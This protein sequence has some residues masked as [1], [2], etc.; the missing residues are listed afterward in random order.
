M[1]YTNPY[2]VLLRLDEQMKQ[3]LG[4]TSKGFDILDQKP[5]L[6][7]PFKGGYGDFIEYSDL[8]E[9]ARIPAPP[10]T[11]LLDDMHF[12]F[13][14]HHKHLELT[15]DPKS[16]TFFLQ[17]IMAAEFQMGA[18]YTKTMLQH[19]AWLLSQR[20]DYGHVDTTWVEECWNDLLFTFRQ[21]VFHRRGVDNNMRALGLTGPHQ[22]TNNHDWKDTRSEYMSI[23][24]ELD[25]Q[26]SF[27]QTLISAFTG[28]ASIV[29]T[30]RSLEEARSVRILSV[31]GMIFL[32]LS[33]TAG[34]FSMSNEYGPGQPKFAQFFAVSVPLLVVVVFCVGMLNFRYSS[35]AS[36]D[37]VLRL[38]RHHQSPAGSPLAAS[39]SFVT[40][41]RYTVGELPGIFADV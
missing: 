40:G 26:I 17:K 30:R 20:R 18:R 13:L 28:L 38:W 41:G 10:R 34:I 27:S 24:A 31:L 5:G 36:V 33:L 12:Y 9:A 15:Q 25:E 2:T 14:N 11:S 6:P 37:R 32:P 21:V 7:E 4:H 3:I 1:M 39:R 35:S 16:V 22:D 29:G 8:H 19:L 23:A